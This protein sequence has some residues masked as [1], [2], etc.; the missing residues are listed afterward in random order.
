MSDQLH[1]DIMRV[2]GNLEGKV[3]G[4][5]ERLDKVNGRLG[6]HD[7]AIATLT[8]S[9]N[10]RKGQATLTAIIWSTVVT[11]IGWFINKS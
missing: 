4:I 6:K 3:D 9:D 8:A 5:N 10:Y 7:E 11:A 2:L 1:N